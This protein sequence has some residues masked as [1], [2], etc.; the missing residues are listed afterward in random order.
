MDYTRHS[1]PSLAESSAKWLFGF[2][3]AAAM[4]LLLPRTVKF[5]IRR[6]FFGVVGE[7]IAVVIAGLLAEK[8]AEQ[9]GGKERH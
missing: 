6:F 2:F 3:G 4:F 9:V 1:E 7:V 5:L 8:A